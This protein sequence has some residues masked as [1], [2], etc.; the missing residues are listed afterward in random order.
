MILTAARLR[1]NHHIGGYVGDLPF[2][3][4]NLALCLQYML[5]VLVFHV[6][7][8]TITE[9]IQHTELCFVVTA[10]LVLLAEAFMIPLSL[11]AV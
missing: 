6:C 4:P 11:Q 9:V 7:T 2:L 5:Y 3:N 8:I 10:T 1:V